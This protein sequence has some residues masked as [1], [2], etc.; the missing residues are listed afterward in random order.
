M[1]TLPFFPKLYEHELFYSGLA[2]Y[3][4][5]CGVL[6]DKQL[7]FD[8]FDKRT[9]FA[10]PEIPNGLEAAIANIRPKMKCSGLDIIENHTL[11]P[12]YT[13]LS[14]ENIRNKIKNEMLSSVNNTYTTAAGLAA[15]MLKT[16]SYMRYCS[17]CVKD[18]LA[19]HGEPFW[20]R[21]WFGIF[22]TCC[23]IHGLTFQST[24][25]LIHDFSRHAFIPL[26]D[27]VFDQ[28]NVETN[29]AERQEQLISK[30]ATKIISSSHKLN[31][32]FDKLTD[33]YRSIAYEHNFN[34]RSS[35]DQLAVASF[36]RQFWKR[37][38]LVDRGFG[39]QDFD[40]RIA[41]IFRKHRK[42]HQYPY[43]IIAGLP[44]FNG[45]IEKWWGALLA[46]SK[47]KNASQ[48]LPQVVNLPINTSEIRDLKQS[49][50][51]LVKQYGPK[52]A[53]Y[54]N[55]ESYNLYTKLY[56]NDKTWLLEINAQN[57]IV[58]ENKNCR[59]NWC[60][61]DISTVKQLFTIL[62]SVDDI[63][64]PRRSK[65]WFLLQLSNSASIEHNLYRLP[66]CA[67]FLDSYNETVEEYQC[68]RLTQVTLKLVSKKSRV[69][70]WQLYRS[71]RINTQRDISSTVIKVGVWCHNWL[72]EHIK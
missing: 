2:R 31:I 35:I 72:I 57:R 45:D 43:H 56:R 18:Q 32:S 21:R 13:G 55:T 67:A 9:I 47:L 27:V 58:R 4:V 48:S 59:V 34:K 51:T 66:K 8:V 11:Y 40:T 1:T 15:C 20:D 54:L 65:R 30:A 46:V 38:W 62:N 69:E 5:R 12:L 60:K 22:T 25:M 23:P 64:S 70:P 17:E 49:W 37:Q 41:Y 50:F 24:N 19:M 16:F 63:Y 14:P 68:R 29:K 44:F 53:R 36:V 33:F 71:A 28:Y 42:Q 7:L 26:V 52:K 6:T 61:R 39:D 10:S 3:K